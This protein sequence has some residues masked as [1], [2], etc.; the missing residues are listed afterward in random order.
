[1]TLRYGGDYNPEQWPEEVWHEDVR[2]MRE[3][4]VNFVTVG[5]FSWALLEPSDG[6]FDFAWLDRVL[7]LLHEN[8]IGVDLATATASPPAWLTTAHPEILPE[9]ENGVRRWPGSRQQ[10]SPTSPIYRRHAVRLVRAMAERYGAHPAVE[11]WHINN[12]Y[13]CHTNLDYSDDAAAAFRDWLRDRYDSIDALNAAWGTRFW[14]QV[15]T[16]FEQILPPRVAPNFRN[17]TQLL[18]FRRFS[19]D[20]L[21]ECFLLEKAVVREISPHIPVTTN[22]IGAFKPVDYWSWAPHVDVVSDDNYADPGDPRS[23]M[24]AAFSRDLMRSLGSGRPWILMEQ[25]TSHVQ[26]R[27]TNL[28]KRSG[29]MRALSLQAVSRGADGINFFQWRQSAS[30]AEKFHSAML[31]HSGTDTRIWRSVVELGERLHDLASVAGGTLEAQVAVVL[32]W[33]SWWAVEAGAHPQTLDYLET[34][35]S[36]YEALYSL[37]VAVDIVH[38]EADLDGYRVVLAPQLYVLGAEGGDNLARF[39]ENGGSL[40]VTYYSAIVDRDDRAHLGGYLGALRSVLGIRIEEFAPLPLGGDGSTIDVA[41]DH[42]DTFSGTIWSEFVTVDT[43]DILAT[44]A[45]DDL[46][47]SAAVTRNGYGSGRAWYVATQPPAT[48]IR[49]IVSR[50]LGD[51]GVDPVL[52]GLP[53]G[54][55]AQKR[56]GVLFVINQTDGDVETS[57]SGF[58]ML[59]STHSAAHTLPPFGAVAIVDEL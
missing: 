24:L 3:A 15:Y 26:W 1:M 57:V 6:V 58:D 10:Y 48:A 17:P 50:V 25:A 19:S 29:Q 31:P 28:R 56:G 11:M 43:A 42:L 18:D 12:E 40:L 38:P 13:G 47:G 33:E 59:T 44:F 30:G 35:H 34:V 54:V 55:E 16:S 14:S 21:L 23:P 4:G 53:A 7:D 36:W 46:A 32:D 45:T 20:A 22:F 49:A 5:V 27:R 51:A 2:L 8:G 52:S 9:D 37:N 39:V 41:G